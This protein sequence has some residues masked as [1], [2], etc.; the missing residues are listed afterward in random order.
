MK[1]ACEGLSS[2]LEVDDLAAQTEVDVETMVTK[3]LNHTDMAT[4]PKNGKISHEPGAS[5]TGSN[6]ENKGDDSCEGVAP[7]LS[8]VTENI[9]K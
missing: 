1:S 6:S 8:K 4:S 5:N 7:K 3:H 9:M 2:N